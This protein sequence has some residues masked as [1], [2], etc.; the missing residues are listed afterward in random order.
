M[1]KII[2][3]FFLG[4]T[5]MALAQQ[6]LINSIA[7]T[8]VE[9]G[10]TVTISG[11]NL[12]GRV[13]FGG[14]EATSVSGSGNV[15]EAVVPA[16]AT[17][18]SLTVLNNMLIAQSSQQF[19]ISYVGS[20][21]NSYDTEF[22]LSSGETDANDICL[23][24]LDGDALGLNDVAIAHSVADN[25]KD[26]ISIYLNQSGP[27][28]TATSFTKQ[29][30][31]NNA[32]NLSGF[33]STACADL[34]NDGK[35]E[36]IFTTNQGTNVKHIYIYQNLSTPG[37]ISLTYLSALSLRLP[38]TS[39]G[40]NRISRVVRAADFDGDGKNDLAV[41]NDTDNTFHIFRNTSSGTSNFSFATPDEISAD[42]DL[43][44][45][46][47]IADLNNDGRPDIISMPFREN[48]T[49]IHILKNRSIIG[50]IDFEAQS[51]VT[52]GGQTN[53]VAAGDF[54][55]DGLIDI[56]VASRNTGLITTFRNSTS[57]S[58]I[59]FDAGEN[60]S[61]SSASPF[62]INLGDINGDGK[63]DI[64]SSFAVGNVVVV[65]NSSTSGNV[66][67]GT[68]QQITT[69]NTTQNVSVGDLNGD[70]KPDIAYTTDVSPGATGKLGTFM[71]RNCVAPILSP[72]STETSFCD[73]PDEFTITTTNS[74]GASYNWQVTPPN[75]IT[76][77]GNNFSTGVNSETFQISGG[78]STTIRVTITSADGLCTT[79]FAEQTYTLDDTTPTADPT[80]QVSPAG[81]LCAGDNVTISTAANNYDNYLWTL[82]DGSTQTSSSISLSPIETNNAG[83]YSL[84][85][86]NTG[87]CTSDEVTQ[88][89]TVIQPPM[90]QVFNNG[91]DTFCSDAANDPQL[92]TS[93]LPG[94]TYQ[95]KLNSGNITGAT[96]STY[97]ADQTGDYSVEV[98]DMATMCSNESDVYTVT[99]ITQPVASLTG[100]TET[101]VDFETT[102]T[103]TSTVQTG[104]TGVNSWTIVGTAPVTTPVNFTGDVFDVTL[105]T[106]GTYQLTLTTS[107]DPTDVTAC[108]NSVIQ[109]V[110][111]SPAPTITFD[112]T[113]GT[114]KCQAESLIV[115]V[116]S[117]VA[118]DI[119]SYSWSVNGNVTTNATA[120]ASTL[121]GVDF[122]YAV[123]EITTTIG[124]T[125]KDSVRIDNF[126]TDADI[127]SPAF[128]VSSDTVTLDEANSIVLAAENIVSG[129]RWAPNSIVDDST[130]TS[131]TVF[132]STSTT[133]VTLTGIDANNCQVATAVTIILDNV[134]PRKT[135]SP[136][137]D[138]L[139][140]SWEILNTDVL[141]G[142][143][144]FI[145]DS[146]GRNLLVRNSPFV[147]NEVWDGTSSGTNVP[148]GL[149][150]FVLKCDDSNLSKSGSIL[151]AR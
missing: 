40:G 83:T 142:C 50:S 116:T 37:A 34:D 84:R 16:G 23:C 149:Y 25:S 107:Y 72:L 12:G 36:L 46:L 104:F 106:E 18:G 109:T 61:I 148:E 108:S 45:V 63:V 147:N 5:S 105:A 9:V 124:C 44:G 11:S 4:I 67:F 87:E 123:L 86:R 77:D 74:P 76:G 137:G 144:I 78:A 3:T 94:L 6:P 110:T 129:I 143:E 132:P 57:G 85:V 141:T 118:A 134:R 26:E 82:P 2:Y 20:T 55:E 32:E 66:S 139:N 81:T 38:N 89:I 99:E 43:S 93:N 111:V 145:F 96:S 21:L 35:P 126:P 135:F 121:I 97:T 51:S 8:H 122:V 10:A 39:G 17:H 112:A 33:I 42:G 31:I 79:A 60:I 70:A 128:D 41:G 47:G 88:S 71:N 59:T 30:N 15:M 102:F 146:R 101:C 69:A 28:G 115:G 131:V 113:D 54:D 24:D 73:T 75:N 138:G 140:D 100:P 120:S 98:T 91:N 29:A 103:S 65:P 52:N 151:L 92:E 7:P 90:L 22:T 114:Q 133:T 49:R 68:E 58:A 48:S 19:Y 80:I 117:P 13:F 127:S 14:V 1:K 62:G 150:Y 119:A 125:V 95:W 53:D 27:A 64:I 136:N 130:A 56:V